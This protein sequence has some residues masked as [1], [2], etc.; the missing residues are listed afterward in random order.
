MAEFLV[1]HVDLS[2]PPPVMLFEKL[3]SCAYDLTDGMVA[4]RANFCGNK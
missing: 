3:Q 2:L 4:S 1:E